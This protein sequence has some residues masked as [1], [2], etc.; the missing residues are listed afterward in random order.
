M[1]TNE[2]NRELLPNNPGT[3]LACYYCGG[4]SGRLIRY[5]SSFFRP[6]YYHPPCYQKAERGAIASLHP[7]DIAEL[8]LGSIL[9]GTDPREGG[10]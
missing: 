2:T 9:G 6:V 8:S 5:P 4:G 10:R 3:L 7:R 1:R